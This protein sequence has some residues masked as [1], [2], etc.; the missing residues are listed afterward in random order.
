MTKKEAR[1]EII[2]ICFSKTNK[3]IPHIGRESY[4]SNKKELINTVFDFHN[5][6]LYKTDEGGG[7][8]YA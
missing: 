4:W 5:V 3:F 7:D 1:K 6:K 8:F 2:N